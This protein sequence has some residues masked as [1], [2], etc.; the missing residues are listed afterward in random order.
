MLAM[1]SLADAPPASP[2]PSGMTADSAA[3]R[4]GLLAREIEFTE[5]HGLRCQLYRIEHHDV[6]T[7]NPALTVPHVEKKAE[8]K[9]LLAWGATWEQAVAHFNSRKQ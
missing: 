4:T 3:S 2:A 7:S 1:K 6:F 5:N 9:L 8:F